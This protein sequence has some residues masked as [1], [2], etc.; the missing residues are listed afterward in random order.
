[1]TCPTCRKPMPATSTSCP[2]CAAVLPTEGALAPAP[3]REL[4]GKR[5]RERNWKDEVRERVDRRR[6]QVQTLADPPAADLPLFADVGESLAGSRGDAA[7]PARSARASRGQAGRERPSRAPQL[8]DAARP[9]R[10]APGAAPARGPELLD[11]REPSVS[12]AVERS[13]SDRA[14]LQSALDLSETGRLTEAP[15]WD[16][17]ADAADRL[18]VHSPLTTPTSDSSVEL[19]LSATHGD[20]PAAPRVEA[21]AEPPGREVLAQDSAARLI[22]LGPAPA[23]SSSVVM[24]LGDEQAESEPERSAHGASGDWSLRSVDEAVERPSVRR[25]PVALDE[26]AEEEDW[27]YRTEPR[28]AGRALER[29]AE[30]L[31]RVQAGLVDLG[32]VVGLLGVVTW[33]AA[34]MA[35]VPLE[36]LRP[37]WPYLAGY[38]L[39]LALVYAAYFTGTTG[40]T[41]GKI[42]LG[43]R[44]VDT[45]GRAPGYGRALL[46]AL[47]GA[48]ASV[49]AGLGLA[50]M[51]LD[52]ARR[53]FHDRLCGTRVVSPG[54]ADPA[55]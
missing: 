26:P 41:I 34:R 52:P 8:V 10:A 39:F 55:R 1:M 9:R 5:R 19:I 29:P 22:E 45:A 43:L 33:G 44:V 54:Q 24:V 51:F 36:G 6:Q 32:V 50:S 4:P 23:E 40:Q 12:R 48:L 42:V 3:L 13:S 28:P 2:A 27:G 17:G 30:P 53:A 20:E 18:L 14:P 25:R 35:K 21:E 37:A 47:L 46:R 49:A 31:E 11:A 7:P 15:A 16:G 38:G